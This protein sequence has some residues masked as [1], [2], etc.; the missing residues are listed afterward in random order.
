VARQLGA[1]ARYE[2][3][4]A[5]QR[6]R[7]AKRQV[8]AAG[9]WGGGRRPY[10]FDSDGVT[11]RPD[12]AAI[13]ADATD[14]ILLGGSLRSQAA[15]LNEDGHVTSTGRPWAPTE[16]KKVLIRPRNAGL[17]EHRGEIIGTAEWPTI[18]EADKWRAVRSML[19]R[20]DRRNT[21]A[22]TGRRWLLSGLARCGAE[23][24]GATMLVTQLA[25]NRSTVPSYTCRNGKCTA[26]NA[27][28]LERY[29]SLAV[30]E[31]LSRP[32][33]IDLLKPAR[34]DVDVRALTAEE[35]A[36]LKRIDDLADDIQLDE[37]TL[38][39]RAQALNRR[40]DEVRQEKADASRGS[41]FHGIVGADDVR[42]AWE[43]FDLGRKRAIIDT[44]MTVVVL[45]ARRGRR[46]G[47]RPGESYFDPTK[48]EI[49][50]R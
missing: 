17:R 46:P 8:A 48:I 38:A 12:E 3:E 4:H 24:C 29:V 45:K 37:R 35:A 34:P 19:T 50:W 20:P 30:V 10:G 41:V 43:S 40:L 2:V 14:A 13:V 31:R 36:L 18:V 21:P 28:E 26:R 39:R 6:Q 22:A 32:D 9:K 33:A 16:L 47:W 1:V 11:V 25:S 49:V 15:K 44:L 23:G 42:A 27:A 7:A 5:I